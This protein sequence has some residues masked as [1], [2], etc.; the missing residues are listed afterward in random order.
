MNKRVLIIVMPTILLVAVGKAHGQLVAPAGFTYVYQP[1]ARYFSA[2]DASLFAEAPRRS[3]RLP[4]VM[5]GAV[6]GGALGVWRF[7]RSSA[8]CDDCFF[9]GLVVVEGAAGA[10]LGAFAGFLLHEAIF[11]SSTK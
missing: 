9:P 2:K 6:V 4:F 1:P 3:Y 5:G 11:N 7:Q 10:A 8:H